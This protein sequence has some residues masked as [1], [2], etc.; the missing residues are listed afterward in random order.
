[1]RGMLQRRVRSSAGGL[2]NT[3]RAGGHGDKRGSRLPWLLLTLALLACAS[4][5]GL[6]GGGASGSS[7]AARLLGDALA[8]GEGVSASALA[9][10]RDAAGGQTSPPPSQAPRAE[11]PPPPS[12]SPPPTPPSP[13]LHPASPP[14][15]DGS[16]R[17]CGIA[18]MLDF[19]SHAQALFKRIDGNAN[20][21]LFVRPL[22]PCQLL[23]RRLTRGRR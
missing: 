17:T 14:P 5:L 12:P 9:S 15:A 3:A 4:L 20:R 7:R 18:T 8:A 19:N 21:G 10:L 2:P 16:C 13:S 1:M 11:S 23:P 6:S 22:R